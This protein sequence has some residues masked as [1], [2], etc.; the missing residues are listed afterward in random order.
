MVC[1]KQQMVELLD[2]LLVRLRRNM[3]NKARS[4]RDDLPALFELFWLFIIIPT[5]IALSPDCKTAIFMVYIGVVSFIFA[6]SMKLEDE[7][8]ERE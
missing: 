6:L 5:L 3:N 1:R 2:G 7:G 4:F 8:D